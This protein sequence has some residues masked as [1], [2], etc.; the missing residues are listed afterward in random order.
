MLDL[1]CLPTWNS[2]SSS[3]ALLS[4]EP[5][6]LLSSTGAL[7]LCDI[8]LASRTKKA[9]SL[10]MTRIEARYC[11]RHWHW[12][13]LNA[14]DIT[15]EF[16]GD[17]LSRFCRTVRHHR[18]ERLLYLP[19]RHPLCSRHCAKPAAG[20]HPRFVLLSK[21]LFHQLLTLHQAASAGQKRFL[22]IHEYQSVTLLNSVRHS[23]SLLVS[24]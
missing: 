8:L 20:L 5:I 21:K 1:W 23:K 6:S 22:S 14:T 15:G 2:G 4:T 18:H 16:P 17:C 10:S 9:M 7:L 13:G 24:S 12:H 19:P 3:E 11:A